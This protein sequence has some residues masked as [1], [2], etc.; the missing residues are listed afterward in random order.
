MLFPDGSISHH[1]SLVLIYSD[2]EKQNKFAPDLELRI[3]TYL[4]LRKLCPGTWEI[5]ILCS[6]ILVR[7]AKRMPK[8]GVAGL[9]TKGV[10]EIRN[11]KRPTAV[12]CTRTVKYQCGAR[13]ERNSKRICIF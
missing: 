4:A 1:S 8:Q 5:C 7:T 10:Q 2:V 12:L 9:Q 11:S 13:R 3:S 6:P